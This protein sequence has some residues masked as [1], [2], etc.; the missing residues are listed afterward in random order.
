VSC[1]PGPDG[2]VV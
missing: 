2:P 1:G